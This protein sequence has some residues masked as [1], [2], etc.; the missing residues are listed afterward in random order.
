MASLG[1]DGMVEGCFEYCSKIK[2]ELKTSFHAAF[3]RK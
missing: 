3:T 1:Q 2:F